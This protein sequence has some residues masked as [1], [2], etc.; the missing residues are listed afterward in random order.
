MFKRSCLLLGCIR[1]WSLF[2]SVLAI[3]SKIVGSCRVH[4][5][6]SLKFMNMMRS[7]Y[8]PFSIVPPRCDLSGNRSEFHAH[9]QIHYYT[10]N[11]LI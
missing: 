1:V 5:Y 10:V 4:L 3:P 11:P 8:I 9:G 2:A 7:T 6:R